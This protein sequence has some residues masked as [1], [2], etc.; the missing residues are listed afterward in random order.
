M[1]NHK[2]KD[3]LPINL[4]I[5]VCFILI[6]ILSSTAFA[7]IIPPTKPIQNL[8]V[9]SSTKQCVPV[10]S[11]IVP[12]KNT[13]TSF[14]EIVSRA[15]HHSV[16]LLGET[17]VNREHHRWQLQVLA[18]LHAIRPDMVIGFEMFPRSVQSV[19]DQWVAG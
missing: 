19:L 5:N 18:A 2:N 8:K 9:A 12:G 14:T 15:N 6:A 1:T 13:P 11:W 4:L 10:A 7:E 3:K 17:H 16:I